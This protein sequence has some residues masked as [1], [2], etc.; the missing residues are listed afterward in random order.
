MHILCAISDWQAFSLIDRLL[1]KVM[2]NLYKNYVTMDGGDSVSNG[3]VSY[4]FTYDVKAGLSLR[5]AVTT[6]FLMDLVGNPK[7]DRFTRGVATALKITQC[8]SV[9]SFLTF[10]T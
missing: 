1:K 5:W 10:V 9:Y 7:A 4:R 6:R 3:D 2:L 8:M